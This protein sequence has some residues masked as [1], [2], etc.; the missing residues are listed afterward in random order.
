[1]STSVA[2]ARQMIYTPSNNEQDWGC[3]VSTFYHGDCLFVMTHDIPSQS[4]DL[5]YLDPPF[6]TG[7]I[8]IGRWRPDAMEV[9]YED[10]KQFWGEKANVMR[11]KAPEWLTH[12][13]LTRPDF[14]SYL[15]YM[16]ERLQACHRVLKLTG[17]IYLH[18]DPRASHYLKMVMDEL[19]GQENLLSE[20]IWKRTSAHSSAKRWGP[21]FDSI[22][23]YSKSK[24]YVW[25]TQYNP[26]DDSYL[27]RLC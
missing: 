27:A 20:I 12:I 15:F 17:S 13:A 5:I 10:S 4:V 7:R 2:L 14:A 21:N 19:V 6:F 18:C 16:M 24:E 8:Q 26:Y 1:M 25:N 22:L 9:T 3:P 11:D 23:F